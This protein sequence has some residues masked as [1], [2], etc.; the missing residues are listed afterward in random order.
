MKVTVCELP[1]D[2]A[3]FEAAWGKLVRYLDRH[4]SDFFLLPEI[5]FSSWIFAA[6][7]FDPGAWRDAMEEHRRWLRRIPELGVPLVAGTR[8]VEAG[9]RRFNEGF[10]W[11]EKGGTKRVHRKCYLPDEPGYYEARW[12]GR[13]G[14]RFVPF[15]ARGWKM[16]FMTCSDLWSMANA[17]AYGKKGTDLVLV[18]R[19][20]GENVDRWLS[21]GKTASVISGAFCAS[22]N[23]RGKKGAA[24]FGGGGWVVSPDGEALGVTTE[25]RPFVT[26]EIDRSEAER[27]KKTYPRDSLEPD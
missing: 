11:S 15:G 13:G 18:P 10:A 2:R 14:R 22:S 24:K 8:P 1:D 9:G 16:G 6:P 21:G 4:P 20:T 17:R 3:K 7:K 19:A 25:E 12:Y 5:P 27:A 26:V 23:R